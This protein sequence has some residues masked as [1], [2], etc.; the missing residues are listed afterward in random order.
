MIKII[1][2]G[3]EQSGSTRLYNL[4]VF[5]CQILKLNIKYGWDI[6]LNEIDENYDV[7]ISKLHESSEHKLNF[8]DIVLLPLRDMRDSYISTIKRNPNK[9]DYI[10]F[11]KKNIK[12]FENVKKVNNILFIYENYNLN[13]IDNLLKKI[14][15]KLDLNDIFKIMIKLDNLHISKEIPKNDLTKD[16]WE[17]EIYCKTLL[18]QSHNTSGGKIGKY[19]EYFDKNK[20]NIILKD[21]II[22]N[23]LNDYDY[24]DLEFKLRLIKSNLYL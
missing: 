6:N 24:L 2:I 18:S 1:V 8:F 9:K 19:L 11:I 15:L 23:F 5:A 10:Y 22:Y 12:I 21:D 7:I 3:P 20:N 17:S 16:K 14:N 13:Y 4:I